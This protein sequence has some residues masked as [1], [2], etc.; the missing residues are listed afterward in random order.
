MKRCWIDTETT[1]LDPERNGL[2][3]LAVIIEVDGLISAKQ[4]FHMKPFEYD[5]VTEKALEI[6]KRTREEIMAYPDPRGVHKQVV[7][8]FSTV[9]DKF[10]RADKFIFAGYNVGFDLDFLSMWFK[11]CQD[12]YFGSWTDG[13]PIDPLPVLRW[14][15]AYG[16]I[17]L[18]NLRL[19][20]VCDHFG[21]ELGEAAH[22]AL[23]DIQATRELATAIERNLHYEKQ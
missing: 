23:A 16:Y 12:D 1:G 8:L 20:T 21:V 15:R 5:V 6:N 2:I 7:D 4:E 10:N 11:K 3:E 17:D 14:L 22:G 19:G 13:H 9:V 18:P